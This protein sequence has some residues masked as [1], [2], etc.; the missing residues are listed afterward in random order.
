MI[1]PVHAQSVSLLGYC[2]WIINSQ[3][4]TDMGLKLVD[5]RVYYEDGEMIITESGVDLSGF[6]TLTPNLV[7]LYSLV[8]VKC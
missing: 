7:S 8:K 5:F 1:N 2:V 3:V 6:N 4:A